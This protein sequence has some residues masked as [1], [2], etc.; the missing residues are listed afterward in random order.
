MGKGKA[1][2][3]TGGLGEGRGDYR[4]I[5]DVRT[6]RR[7]RES[8]GVRSRRPTSNRIGPDV[9]SKTNRMIRSRRSRSP[10]TVTTNPSRMEDIID[11]AAGG[12]ILPSGGEPPVLSGESPA[13]RDRLVMAVRTLHHVGDDREVFLG[14]GKAEP[15]GLLRRAPEQ[16]KELVDG[17]LLSV[18]SAIIGDLWTRSIPKAEP[19]VVVLSG[20]R[21][22]RMRW[23]G[24]L[25]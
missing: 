4:S 2:L 15:S 23:A 21:S 8:S 16:G 7:A 20:D 11:C 3:G 6:T 14:V 13:R 9:P 12:A 25:E 18:H 22:V 19:R 5:A 1:P 17:Q 24:C 10:P